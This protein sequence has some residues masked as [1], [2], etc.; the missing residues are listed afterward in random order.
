MI[1][2]VVEYKEVVSVIS[3]SA[4]VF[5]GMVWYSWL[6]YHN[7]FLNI[8]SVVKRKCLVFRDMRVLNQ[9]S[10]FQIMFSHTLRLCSVPKQNEAVLLSNF[11]NYF[12]SNPIER[13][14]FV[15]KQNKTVMCEHGFRVWFW[16]T[17]NLYQEDRDNK[18]MD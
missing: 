10:E 5:D 3:K 18:K 12:N 15:S 16:S 7:L 4:N 9:S 6:T 8:L 11:S 13:L 1:F 14:Y 2:M 17:L